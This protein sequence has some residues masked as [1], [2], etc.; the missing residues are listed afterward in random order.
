MIGSTR[1]NSV[2]S[3]FRCTRQVCSS[4]DGINVSSSPL[5]GNINFLTIIGCTSKNKMSL[6]PLKKKTIIL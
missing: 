1:F 2:K 6:R 4:T 5:L 3:L